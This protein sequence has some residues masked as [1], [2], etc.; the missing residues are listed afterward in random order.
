MNDDGDGKNYVAVSTGSAW[1]GDGFGW[2]APKAWEEVYAFEYA[3]ATAW[4][5]GSA[6][7]SR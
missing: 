2:V 4:Q 6:Y 1:G 7:A 3:A 5:E